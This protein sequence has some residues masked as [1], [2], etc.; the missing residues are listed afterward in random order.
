MIL[1]KFHLLKYSTNSFSTSKSNLV[2]LEKSGLSEISLL[3]NFPILG[4]INFF[5]T[6]LKNKLVS[7]K[8]LIS[9][10]INKFF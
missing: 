8:K 10:I 7:L 5:E 1:I 3:F 4:K 6:F 9:I 2:T